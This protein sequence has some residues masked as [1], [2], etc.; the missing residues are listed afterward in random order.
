MGGIDAIGNCM[1]GAPPVEGKHPAGVQDAPE[2]AG[3]TI[4]HTAVPMSAHQP[5][6]A[7]LRMR[8]VPP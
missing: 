3:V 4:S 8:L 7:S 6:S 5:T 2:R 1:T